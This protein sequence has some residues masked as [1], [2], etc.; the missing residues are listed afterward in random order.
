MRVYWLDGAAAGSV[1]SLSF[2]YGWCDASD[3]RSLRIH[4][5]VRGPE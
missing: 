1:L 2:G 4:T 3:L 5:R